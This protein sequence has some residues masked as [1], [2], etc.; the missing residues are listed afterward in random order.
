MGQKS[1]DDLFRPLEVKEGTLVAVLKRWEKVEKGKGPL[2]TVSLS[3]SQAIISI[4]YF[5]EIVQ[6]AGHSIILI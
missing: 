3:F 4:E 6:E 1:V 5:D 2:W